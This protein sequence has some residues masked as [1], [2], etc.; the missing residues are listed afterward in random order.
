GLFAPGDLVDVPLAGPHTRAVMAEYGELELGRFIG[1]MV[2]GL[3]SELIVD[4]IGETRRRIA[5]AEP[6]SAAQVRGL[7]HALASFSKDMLPQF[8]ALKAFLFE[9]MYRHPLVMGSVEVAK[10]VV[11]E[12]FASLSANPSLLPPDW[13]ALCGKPGDAGTAGIVRDYIAGMT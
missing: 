12:L 8:A 7:D 13:A 3:M 1:E 2:R 4:L 9:R 6:R 10:Q 5:A 11:G